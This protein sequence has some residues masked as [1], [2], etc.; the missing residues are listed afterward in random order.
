MRS[1]S[2]RL[3]GLIAALPLAATLAAARPASATPLA[4]TY[5]IGSGGDYATMTA[6]TTALTSN[7]ISAPVSFLIK[8]GTYSET[9]VIGSIAGATAVNRIRFV[10][11]SG[12]AADVVLTFAASLSNGSDSPVQLN[13]AQYVDFDSLTITTANASS[14]SGRLVNISGTTKSLRFLGSTLNTFGTSRSAIRDDGGALDSLVVSNCQIQVPQGGSLAMLLQGSGS[15]NGV[16]IQGNTISV[17][18]TTSTGIQITRATPGLLI[19]G[20]TITMSG[21]GTAIYVHTGIAFTVR[22]N[23]I[24]GAGLALDLDGG[25]VANNMA[26]SASP[27]LSLASPSSAT[28]EFNSFV[29]TGAQCIYIPNGSVGA[30]TLLDNVLACPGGGVPLAF[31][32]ATTTVL[33]NTDYND[34][35][36]TGATVVSTG[37]TLYA[38]LAAWHTASGFDTHSVSA[39][40][41]FVST[42]DLHASAFAISNA[43]TP[44]SAVLDDFDG[45]I[46]S[47]TTPDIGADEFSAALAPLAGSYT[48]GATG[49]YLSPAAAA[50]DVSVRG[51]SA[52]VSFV[53]QTGTY[54]GTITLT[55]VA[56]TNAANRVRFVAQTGNAADVT[57]Q[58]PALNSDG[59]DAVVRLDGARYV[60]FDSLTIFAGTT[61][62]N[63]GSLAWML[64]SSRNNR[65][66]NV[67]FN[68]QGQTRMAIRALGGV[69]DSLEVRNCQFTLPKAFCYIMNLGGGSTYEGAI[70]QGNTAQCGAGSNGMSFGGAATNV[71]IQANTIT[72]GGN[73]SPLIVNSVANLTL[74]GNKFSGGSTV[75][76]LESGTGGLVANNMAS[77]SGYGMIL[78]NP[79]PITVAFN[80]ISTSS[81]NACIYVINSVASRITLKNNILAA[82]GGSPALVLSTAANGAIASSDYNDLYATGMPLAQF[83]TTNYATLASLRAGTGFETHSVFANPGF[84]SVADLHSTAPAI[85]NS[86][87]PL[88]SVLDDI[89]GDVRSVSTPDIGADEFSTSLTPLAGTYTVGASGVYPTPTAA[90]ADVSLRGISAPVSFLIQSG[91][92]VGTMTLTPVAGASAVNRVRFTAQS[93]NAS[94]V[95]LQTPSLLSDGSDAPVRLDGARYID[96]DSLT[97]LTT[98]TG[99]SSSNILLA[100]APMVDRIQ[101]C[102]LSSTGQNHSGVRCS[103]GNP[104]SLVVT[105]CQFVLPQPFCFAVTLTNGGTSEG[106]VFSGNTMTTGTTQNNGFA[107][108]YTAANMTITGNT[109]ALGGGGTALQMVGTTNAIVRG[110]RF[111]GCQNGITTTG[112]GGLIANNF[113]QG[114]GNPLQLSSP[115]PTT[116]AYNSLNATAGAAA[117][118]IVSS[119]AGM[120]TLRNNV[121]ACPAGD[122]PFNLSSP[123]AAAIASSDYNDF[124]TTGVNAAVRSPSNFPTLAAW[125][126]ATG[127]D[128]H[129]V[130]ANPGYVSSSDL[131]PTAP[132]LN[133][134]GTPVASVLDDIDGNVRSASTPDM[135]A[136][137]FNTSLT[138]L[139]GTY[140]VGASGVY[141]TPAAA[142]GDVS[143]RGISAP[144]SFLIQSGT[145]NST[146][147]LTPIAGANAA[148]RVRFVSQTGNAADVTL[149]GPA[150]LSDGSDGDVRLDG[151]RYVDLD[152]LTVFATGAASNAGL[153]WMIHAALV[154]R[155]QGCI[156]NSAGLSRAGLR[157][158]GANA[159]SIVVSNCQFVMPQAFCSAISLINGG[160]I[161]GASLTGNTMIVTTTTQNSGII[162]TGTATNMLV[163]GNTISLDGGGTAMQLNG[164]TSLIVRANRLV[165]N[166]TGLVIGSGGGLIAN[167]MIQSGGSSALSV[168]NPA[169]MSVVFNSLSSN[170]GSATFSVVSGGVGGLTMKDNI[171][172]NS[173][174]GPGLHT[175]SVASVL[176]APDYN[177]YFSAGPYLA[178]YSS[179]NCPTVASIQAATS[180]DAHSVNVAPAFTSTTDLHTS[181]PGLD[182]AGTPF[183]GVVDDFDGQLRNAVTPDIG[184]DEF[185]NGV[186]DV[187]PPNTSFTSG[188]ADGGWTNS[189]SATFGWIGADDISL[190]ATLRYETSLDGGAY[191]APTFSTSGTFGSLTEGAHSLAVVAIDQVGNID[192]TP[193]SR[194]FN[195][196][197]TLPDTQILTGP[198]EGSSVSAANA[199]FTVTGTDNL[200]AVPQLQYSYRVDGGA[201]TGFATST[202]INLTALA[203]GA[204]TLDVRTVDLAGNV[205]AS[206]VTRHFTVA[207]VY[208]LTADWSDAANPNG[209]WSYNQGT[210]LLPHVAAWSVNPGDWLT[211]QPAWA[212]FASGTS[213]EPALFKASGT[214]NGAHDWQNGDFICHTLD[215]TNG[216][217]SGPASVIWTNPSP[218]TV[219]I[220][221]AAWMGRDIGR[222]NHW[223]LWLNGTQL[224]AG[225]VSSGDAYSRAT[226]MNFT[227]GTGGPSAISGLTL[228]TGDVIKL[229]MD[230]NGVSADFIGVQ[231]QVQTVPISGI[232]PKPVLIAGPANGGWSNA[233]TAFTWTL[234]AH[235]APPSSITYATRVDA[236]LTSAFAPDTTLSLTSLAPGAHT[237]WV[238][239]KDNLNRRDSTTTAWTVDIV[240]PTVAFSG[241]PLEGAYSTASPTF[242]WTSNDNQTSLPQM[243]YA[244]SLDG[245]AFTG[246]ALNTSASLSSLT[247]GAHTLAVHS[248]DLAGNLS[249]D[250]LRHWNVDAIAPDTQ[251]LTGPANASTVTT[252]SV[253]YGYTGT[254]D[255]TPTPSLLYRTRLD[256]GAW[257]AASSATSTTLSNVADGAHV[258]DVRA[259]D[260]GG[261]VDATPAS[262]TVTIDALGPVITITAGPAS[263]AC[264]NT[265]GVT[266]NWTATDAVTPQGSILYAWQLDGGSLTAF[267]ATLTANPTGLAEGLHTFTIQAKDGSNNISSLAR[268]FRV[269]VTQPLVN[270][271]TTHVTDATHIRVQCTATDLGGVTGYRVQVSADPA[272]GS[273][274]ADVNIDAT[275]TYNFTGSPGLSYYARAQASD[276]AGNTTAFSG[277]SNVAILANLPNLVVTNVTA[278]PSLTA[279]QA[280][281]VQYT[282]SNSGAG[283]TSAPSWSENIYLSPTATYN[284]ATA[285]LLAQKT[286]Q[287][288][289][290]PSQSYTST[291][292]VTIPGGISGTYYVLVTADGGG[293]VSETSKTDNTTASSSIA[294]ALGAYGDLHVISAV[295]P[296]TALSSDSITVTWKVRNDGTGRTD[297]TQW[298]DTIFLSNDTVFDYSLV[299][300]GSIRVQDQPLGQFQHTGA[301]E[302][303]SS[304]TV[305]AKVKLPANFGGTRYI[306]PAADLFA[307]QIS[308]VV[309]QQGAVFENGNDINALSSDSL[310]VTQEQP[311]DLTVDSV[312]SSDT[313]ATGGTLAVTFTIGNHGFNATP[314]GF[315]WIDKVWLS[316]DATLDAGDVLLGAY[317]HSGVV[318]LSGNYSVT[319][320]VPMPATLSGTFRLIVQTDANG[321]L[322]EY[323]ENNNTGLK[324]TP[325][326]IRQAPWANLVPAGESVSDTIPAGGTG[327]ANWHVTN[328]GGAGA[329]ATWTDRIEIGTSP[330]WSSGLTSVGSLRATRSLNAGQAYEGSATLSIPTN[331]SG[332]YYVFVNSDAG[333]EVFENT[334]EGDNVVLIGSV[335]VKPYPAVDLAVSGLT[336]PG[337]AVAG[338]PLNLSWTVTNQGV[339]PTLSSSW[340]ED[341]WLSLDSTFSADDILLS[342]PG[343][344]GALDPGAHYTR[345]VTV[346]PTLGLSGTYHLIV[347][348]DPTGASHDGNLANN[349][350]AS[351]GT[352]NITSPLA[353][354]LTV[355][356]VSVPA[357]LTSGQPG[358]V[359]FDVHNGGPGAVPN[360]T[361]FTAVY[362]SQD[363]WLDGSDFLLGTVAGPVGFASGATDHEQVTAAMPPWAT[364]AY[365]VIVETDSRNE[366]WE[367]GSENDNS[368]TATTQLTLPPPADLIV[369]NVTVPGAAVPGQSVTV[370]Y[371]LSNVGTNAAVGEVQN[372]VYVSADQAFASQND[373]LVGVEVANINIP[374]GGSAHLT[375]HVI[376]TQP[377]QV[378]AQGNVTALLPPISPGNY[379]AI[380]N[381]NI[382][383]NIRELVT[384]NNSAVSAAVVQTDLPA[385]TLGVSAPFSLTNGQ[386]SFYKVTVPA[387]VD[388]NFTLGTNVSDATNGIFVAYG[389]TPRE[390]DF[391]FTGPAGF[392]GNPSV[393]VPE[394]Q[395]G[396]YYVMVLARSLGSVATSE[397]MTLLAQ[398]L[399]FS[400]SSIT[401]STGG[402]DGRVTVHVFGAAFRDTTVFQLEQSG[403]VRTI[404]TIVQ[405][406]NSTDVLVRFNLPGL[407]QGTF[408]FVARNG[409]NSVILPGAFAVQPARPLA[410]QVQTSNPDVLRKNATGN[411][412]VRLSNT[413]NQD[414]PVVTAR[415]VFPAT[416]TL[417]SLSLDPALKSTSQLVHSLA[418]VSGDVVTLHNVAGGDSLAAVDIIGANLAPGETRTVTLGVSG[419]L[420]SPYS[421]RVLAEGMTV[422]EFL[423]RRAADIEAA[424]RVLVASPIGL[425]D[426]L[427]QLA[428]GPYAFRDEALRR[429]Y[430]DNGIIVDGDISILPS[431][432]PTPATSYVQPAG[433]QNLLTDIATNVPCVL[434]GAIPECKPDAITPGSALPACVTIYNCDSPVPLGFFGGLIARIIN[435]DVLG[436]ETTISADTRIVVPCDPNLMSGPAGF[437]A[438]HWV[439][440]AT[441]MNYRVDF[442]NLPGVGAAPAQ[443]VKVSVPIDPSLDVTTFR[444]GDMGFGSTHTI[445][446]GAL[447]T[448]YSGQATYADIGL[449]VRVTAGINPT[450]RLAT[451]TFTSID[452]ATGQ[453]PTNPFIGFLPVNDLFSSGT[454]YITYT[455]QPSATAPSGSTVAAQAT[456]QFDANTPLATV[457]ASNRVDTHAP[458]SLV[459]TGIQV[460]DTTRVRVHW[461]DADDTTGAGLAGATLYM[462]TDTGTFLSI[463]SAT[464][465]GNQLD[466]PVARGHQYGFYTLAADNAGNSEPQKSAAEASVTI[467]G[468]LLDAKPPLIPNVTMLHPNYPNPFSGSTTVRFDLATESVVTLEV[469]DIQGR[470]VLKPIEGKSFGAGTHTIEIRSL[471]AGPGVYFYRFHAG[472]FEQT[473]RMVMLH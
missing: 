186:N 415:V 320:G 369:Q 266:F 122:V 36:T 128:M 365:Y 49:A 123:A 298:Y 119:N 177:D 341:A 168:T 268:T 435:S 337:S 279:G 109:F 131:H 389:R 419:F 35:Y 130:S 64:N 294:I 436:F 418:P 258:F 214:L 32:T 285:T 212:R 224:T 192:P 319:A 471:P 53:I 218:A 458:T 275:G 77:G 299:G 270:A 56:G 370:S 165:A 34:F 392:S 280:T 459:L 146:I 94:D 345:T 237:M 438:E 236:G 429:T 231:M 41:N 207:V 351:V 441:N 310:V 352:I 6:A 357:N 371:T 196:D 127:F 323:L 10:S 464:A 107:L 241:G 467:S 339:G 282:V 306:I 213:S 26:Q 381:A 397:N 161:D 423:N 442:E 189:N 347:R 242:S 461:T 247:S 361:W 349:V 216:I 179:T 51:I 379:Y 263:N 430:V 472:S 414:V 226:P 100:H 416:S 457:S 82:P 138:P 448:S 111:T 191:S 307:T 329:S 17:G 120:L 403:I 315:S 27:V 265:S 78:N 377:L 157:S 291:A 70:I 190:P 65:F 428:N 322:L 376:P 311:P 456:I 220:S 22:G 443:V 11:Q 52:P 259:Q 21:G 318:P 162:C 401:P 244:Y 295:A 426:S 72:M 83:G 304:Y 219:T 321:Q 68:S 151:G 172:S 136:S 167:N 193:A 367:N 221:G 327:T 301:L 129:S 269:D 62:A 468:S 91:S 308:Q 199:I 227:A 31:G 132:A 30:A 262:R 46:R 230:K 184:A 63:S 137:E 154:D 388:L 40:P 372:A 297:A 336:M 254:D 23:R 211:A 427:V 473:R 200:T 95:T 385:L 149:Q 255:L 235:T 353:P 346:T 61:S 445:S 271:P 2:R 148:N 316:S 330:T 324:A 183:A 229:Q 126:A 380:V 74:R 20:N 44:L 312:V 173:G 75:I 113:L 431:S 267:G 309:T 375:A 452:P 45:D 180:A 437:G 440:V 114:T 55:T 417:K 348:S 276:C 425:P 314:T 144:V 150:I 89:D 181:A 273:I 204:H 205:D 439:G 76:D 71:T 163:S 331:F 96:L 420:T 8:T 281:S 261:N 313:S 368:A 398:T 395:A 451:W 99:S 106:A 289:L 86:G 48:V 171:L 433:P 378:D 217:G 354:Q 79:A 50:A 374:P 421:L 1:R 274:A 333:N 358:T 152:S 387:G 147:T 384:N 25:F 386:A 412:I 407:T 9:T 350:A 66:Q 286:N 449:A 102:V 159:D 194:A 278:A 73:G 424:R 81:T 39:N 166:N 135:G 332:T 19:S 317:P 59:S 69:Q 85:N 116:I 84:V 240:A 360:A 396:T 411:F 37:S 28:I 292:S 60:D 394:T 104:D 103:T 203:L 209:V 7:G 455:A 92:Y 87:T 188:V 117:L 175:S 108:N 257:S 170:S 97:V 303:D 334:N 38:S 465:T 14:S 290:G 260:A 202:T 454:G 195:V 13:G 141:P 466:V 185:T 335:Y 201:Y 110:N 223:S 98:G 399:P 125:Q 112:Q 140:T 232:A 54:T 238:I 4:G 134:S 101:G 105:N 245:A 363:P 187:T 462:K 296:P 174:T 470:R 366:V 29:A 233:A 57:L 80:T 93:G 344:S 121:M 405:F 33:A 153:V 43:G 90:A 164:A 359:S 408:D 228:G 447:K 5:V 169:A 364:G 362:L 393:L 390:D 469:F 343:R 432:G 243:R 246:L 406:N 355:A 234:G 133:N 88:G 239:A 145:Y 24:S 264:I 256:G 252:N 118:Y 67:A 413:S 251:I 302:K 115:L 215:P 422:S 206:P 210:T 400:L 338:Q 176:A 373:P 248:A 182:G 404:G 410:V 453:Q 3:F 42:S 143:L 16:L 272:F 277:P 18:I 434:A 197:L 225:D 283:S 142:A 383:E 178:T 15:A 156:F 444:L 287:T 288:E 249:T 208:D 460:L 250:A 155:F 300:S 139:A 463:G 391:D 340:G 284:S 58:A 402:V 293:V 124:Y 328:L 382:R 158:S 12:N 342:S 160:T 305:T 325:L 356:N 222:S 47:L 253:T 326:S 409:A 446:V 450:T 198:A